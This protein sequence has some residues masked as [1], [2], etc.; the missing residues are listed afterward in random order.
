[1]LMC[2]YYTYPKQLLSIRTVFKDSKGPTRPRV[3]GRF[4][5]SRKPRVQPRQQPPVVMASRARPRGVYSHLLNRLVSSIIRHKRKSRSEQ[6]LIS[7]GSLVLCGVFESRWGPVRPGD[8][9]NP[10]CGP[11][12]LKRFPKAKKRAAVEWGSVSAGG[13]SRRR[14]RATQP[15]LFTTPLARLFNNVVH[16]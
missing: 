1:M 10:F 13:G 2:P 6:Y 9:R 14:S 4:P 5:R 15:A 16:G 8:R 11:T 12:L 7:R 3:K